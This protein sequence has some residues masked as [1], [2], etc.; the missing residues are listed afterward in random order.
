MNLIKLKYFIDLVDSGSFTKTGELNHVSQTSI[1]QQISSLEDHFGGTLVDRRRKPVTTTPFGQ[2]LYEESKEV[3]RRYHLLEKKMTDFQTEGLVIRI[4]YS[5]I[6]E[7]P[8]LLQVSHRLEEQGIATEIRKA[9]V[10]DILKAVKDGE[11]D[12]VVTFSWAFLQYP[13]IKL[14]TLAEGPFMAGVGPRHPLY[15]REQVSVAEIY[16]YPVVGLSRKVIGR[17]YD[18]LLAKMKADG[19]NVAWNR[20]VDD[21][22]TEI[23]YIQQENLVGFFPDIFPMDKTNSD[24]HLIPIENAPQ[25][26]YEIVAAYDPKKISPAVGKIFKSVL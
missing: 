19:Y 4:L 23:F 13:E 10:V 1:S 7:L 18:D 22:D 6:V 17:A 2:L 8:L 5:S 3:W 16:Q 24:I 11:A 26:R 21:L 12:L 15:H 14:H 25:H 9:T 20:A